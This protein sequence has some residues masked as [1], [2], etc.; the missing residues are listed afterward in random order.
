MADEGLNTYELRN[1]RKALA[2]TD[3]PI[4]IDRKSKLKS[5]AEGMGRDILVGVLGG[6]V[7]AALLGKYS[8]IVGLGL[9]GYGHFS[10]N[11]TVMALGLGMMAT[12][13]FTALTGKKQDVKKPMSDRIKERLEAFKD[14]LKQKVFL[15]KILV[16]EKPIEKKAYESASY[17]SATKEGLSGAKK[18]VLT[19]EEEYLK[20]EIDRIKK[21]TEADVEKEFEAFQ[22]YQKQKKETGSSA[23]STSVKT[24]TS[25]DYSGTNIKPKEDVIDKA[26]KEELKHFDP[27][28]MIF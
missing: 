17:N 18:D 4:K 1:K 24:S 23:K 8:F 3:A 25:D 2:G 20:S 15:D 10:D 13:T 5:T 9:S 11:K 14:E 27:A 16:D 7:A 21:E 28:E 12:G 26:L 19:K 6:G 22:E